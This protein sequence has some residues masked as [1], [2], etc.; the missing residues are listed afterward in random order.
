MKHYRDFLIA[1][2]YD[3]VQMGYWVVAPYN[4]IRHYKHLRLAPSGVVPQ[5]ERRPRPIMDYTFFGTNQ[6][7]VPNV[8]LHAMQFGTALQRILQCIMYCDPSHGPP[9]LAKVDLADGYYRIPLS[10]TTALSLAV[11]IPNDLPNQPSLVAIPLALPMGWAHRPP[12]F[13]AF[14]ETV[15]DIT[16]QSADMLK[17]PHPLLTTTQSTS[18]PYQTTYDVTATPLNMDKKPPLSFTD[19]YI[20]DFM[21]IAQRPCHLDTLNTLLHTIDSIFTDYAETCRR[22]IISRK[23][24]EK[25]DASFST[26]KQLLGWNVNTHTLTISLPKHRMDNLQHLLHSFLHKKRTSTKK[27]KSFLGTLRSTTPAL[28]G[29]THLFSILQHTLTANHRRVRIT[30]LVKAILRD[31]IILAQRAATQPVPMHTT[32]PRAPTCLAATDASSLGLGGFWITPDASILWRTPLSPNIR[33]R[34]ITQHTPEGTLTNSDLELAAMV[35][36]ST[37]AAQ[38]SHRPDHNILLASD[39]TPAVAWATKGS[40][41]STSTNAF[42]LHQLAR[43]RKTWH[44]D[45]VPCFTPGSSNTIAD[46][47]SRFFHLADCDFLHYMNTHY[48]VQPCWTLAPV[49]SD[50]ISSVNLNLFRQLQPLES[51]APGAPLATQ[52]GTSGQ[53]S[54]LS[55]AATPTWR[56]LMTHP[57]PPTLCPLILY[58]R[59]GSQWG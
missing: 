19:V 18:Q 52:H 48:P 23:K 34:I 50:L 25:G 56:T 33:Q 22:P 59:L 37:L 2:M 16:N 8:P 24:L 38:H 9:L 13:C 32:V 57:T 53:T 4:A 35:I 28:Y 51:A 58:R 55:S 14:T 44:F 42:L 49:P 29:A 6:E 11:V 7:L 40:T 3:Y 47:C 41:T 21:V 54:V 31:W 20:D 1:D 46:A 30:S 39:N 43:Q 15:A 45:V 5:R 27:W 26:E 36:G 17:T 12:F 10:A